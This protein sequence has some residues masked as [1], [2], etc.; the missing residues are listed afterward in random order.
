MPK[1]QL[2]REASEG[3]VGGGN[4]E[5]DMLYFKCLVLQAHFTLGIRIQVTRG[6]AMLQILQVARL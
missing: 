2:A 6:K 1:H 3:R 5:V 4:Q